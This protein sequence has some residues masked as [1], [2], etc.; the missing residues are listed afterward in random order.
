M[1]ILR[2]IVTSGLILG[3]ALMTSCDDSTSSKKTKTATTSQTQVEEVK[4]KAVAFDSEMAYSYIQRQVELGYR[5]PNTEA[6]KKCGDWIVEQVKSFGVEVEEQVFD[7]TDYYDKAVKGRNIIASIN[8][9]EPNRI[10]LLAHYDTRAVADHDPHTSNQKLA[11]SG[12]DDGASGVAVL[13]ELLR[14]AQLRKSK[15]GLDVL[16]V[17]LEDGGKKASEEGWCQGSKYW[18]KNPHKKS[19]Q[20]RF[21]VLLDMVGAK[22]ARFCWEAYSR[23]YAA[24]YVY[25]LWETAHKLGWRKYFITRET[26][27][28]TDDHVP[29]IENRSIPTVDIV[30][31][32]DT[33][34]GGFG[35]HWHTLDDSIE[36]ISKETLQAVG[37]TVGTTIENISK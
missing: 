33:R 36:V 32:D 12:A 19:Y 3:F 2:N 1:K 10:I 28:L 20:A 13:L 34:S 31:Y 37:E 30:N 6:H 24:P 5:L 7:G 18:A 11:I 15:M 29:L 8:P 23:A 21:G 22:D 14:Q 35:K 16:F 4:M 17:D 27:A 26:S 9:Q 25:R